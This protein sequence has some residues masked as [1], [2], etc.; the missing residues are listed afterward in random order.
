MYNRID[1]YF[2]INGFYF[3]GVFRIFQGQ[4]PFLEFGGRNMFT[5]VQI[6]LEGHQIFSVALPLKILLSLGHNRQEVEGGPNIL[7]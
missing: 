6:V 7:I 3:R 4:I 2:L 1:P 5:R